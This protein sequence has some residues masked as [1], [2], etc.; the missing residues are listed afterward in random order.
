MSKLPSVI[1]DNSKKAQRIIF[2][3]II[4]VLIS[5]GQAVVIGAD[6][7]NILTFSFWMNVIVNFCLISLPYIVYL[8]DGIDDGLLDK[9]YIAAVSDFEGKYDKV[10]EGNHISDIEKYAPIR[11]EMIRRRRITNKLIGSGIDLKEYILKYE[12]LSVNEINKNADLSELQKGFIIRIKKDK[13]KIK[14][15]SV[16]SLVAYKNNEN[17]DD[18]SYEYDQ[19][20]IKTRLLAL[21]L[22][23]SAT[24][25]IF[26]ASIAINKN[27]EFSFVTILV[28]IMMKA[29]FVFL[30]IRSGKSD[31]TNMITNDKKNSFLKKCLFIERFFEWKAQGMLEPEDYNKKP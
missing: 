9:G 31:G 29:F 23:K 7:S 8:E 17:E 5:F 10:V 19:K 21:R 25:A 18:E 20:L 28:W 16:N 22:S 2:L 1:A 24:F 12:K 15:I 13:T 30:A 14:K 4:A 3:A 26:L 6:L 27:E 11:D